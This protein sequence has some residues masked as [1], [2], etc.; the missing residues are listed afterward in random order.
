QFTKIISAAVKS[1]ASSSESRFSFLSYLARANY[2]FKNRYL[3]E[4]TLR[5]DGSSRFGSESRYGS[6]PAASVGWVV[7]EED[8]LK[9]NSTLS[10]L[11]LRASYGRTGNAEIDNFG[12]RTLYTGA[13]YAGV[14]G[15]IP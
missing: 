8:F 2:K 5:I 12:P 10:F 3:L 11:K 15:T 9:G 13:N 6:F 4:A 14:P 1:N 7:S